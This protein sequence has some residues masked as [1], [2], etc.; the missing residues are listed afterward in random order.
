VALAAG[1]GCADNADESSASPSVPAAGGPVAY[2]DHWHAAFGVFV[3]DELLSDPAMTEIASG[4]HTHGDGVVHIHPFSREGAGANAT[5]GLFLQDTDVELADGELA[6][7]D[8]TWSDGDECDG[9]PA[10]VVV[11]RWDDASAGGE[12]EIVTDDF[13]EIRFR[14]DGE[15]YTIA[16]VPEGADIPLPRSAGDL[17]ALGA[18][19]SGGSGTSVAESVPVPAPV[20]APTSDP[21]GQDGFY[22]VSTA[23][24]ATSPTCPAGTAALV[25]AAGGECL[26]L[27]GAP[28]GMDA[29]DRA[30]AEEQNGRWLVRLRLTDAGIDRFNDLAE[31]CYQTVPECGTGRVAIV[32]DGR[33]QSAPSIIEP[34]YEA[35]QIQ[36][37]GAFS[38]H[39]A[40]ALAAA[41]AG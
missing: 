5:L 24:P 7:G 31:Q 11:A 2:E 16:F 3:C 6:V 25:G 4:I 29:V 36:I 34:S 22:P 23:V 39:G 15:A 37:S 19:D 40:R 35:D 20:D 18:A 26:T 27:D 28:V 12:P 17:A 13:D 8:E 30:R 21:V 41:V 33:V 32:V 9:E 38:E 1:A 14:S 10:R